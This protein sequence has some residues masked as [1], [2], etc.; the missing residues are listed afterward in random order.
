MIETSLRI[1]SFNLENFPGERREERAQRWA[2]LRPQLE[3]LK[4]DVLCL[5]EVDAEKQAGL[6][7]LDALRELL[8]E[9]PYRDFHF[10]FT[11][12][13]VPG[14][15]RDKHNLVILSRWPF[16]GTAQ[17]TNDLVWPPRYRAVT[18][19]P[20]AA[21][22]GIFWDRPILAAEIQLPGGRTLHILNLHLRAPLASVIAGQK[23]G[24][25]AW[26]TVAGWAEGYY[27]A[28]IKRAGQALEARFVVDRVLDNEPEALIAVCGDFNAEE[29]EVPARILI[30]D[31]EDTGNGQ[32][33]GRELVV[34]EHRLPEHRRFT[35]IHA[36]RRQMLD[37]VLVSRPL[38]A[39]FRDIEVHNEALGDEVIAYTMVDRTP[40]SYHAPVVAEFALPSHGGDHL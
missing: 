30:G 21:E 13:D 33:T 23:I 7:N 25:F 14:I 4:A 12:G 9:T 16:V 39:L 22:E 26:K 8:S 17:Y 10:A 6:R 18:A 35:I 31:T 38:L 32:L 34:L 29:R 2:I 11:A 40:E 19:D 37:R 15:P 27:M 28:A 20:T 36:G 1:G 24:P 5:Q 3:R